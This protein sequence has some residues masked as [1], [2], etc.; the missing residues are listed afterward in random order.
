MQVKLQR[1]IRSCQTAYRKVVKRRVLL[2]LILVP[3]V[4]AT[5][6]VL[7]Q[8]KSAQLSAQRTLL[9]S[10]SS[11]IDGQD[12]S[13]FAG[14][15]QAGGVVSIHSL[16]RA[17]V[18]QDGSPNQGNP[19]VNIRGP[20]LEA[21]GPFQLSWKMDSMSGKDSS[22]QLYSAVPVIYDEWRYEMPHVQFAVV[23]GS[24]TVMVWDGTNDAPVSSK[25]YNVGELTAYSFT[26]D[27][28]G[29]S[30][31]VLVDGQYLAD[32]DLRHD[33]TKG[34]MWF[35]ADAVTDS[36]GW[37]LSNLRAAPLGKSKLYVVKAPVMKVAALDNSLRT[38]AQQTSRHLL[39][40]AAIAENPLLTD[41]H[42]RQIAGG[43]FSMLTPENAM[44][45]QFIHPQRGIYSFEDADSLVEFAQA[46]NMQVHGHAL[47]FGEA[48]PAWM[49]QASLGERQA[50]MTD[51]IKTIV[52]HYKGKV[53]E[54]DVVNE[55]LAD[56]AV[57]DTT[58]S[59][60]RQTIWYQAMGEQ[61]I[62]IA[63]RTARETDP[64]AKLYIN[65][66]GLEADG[67]R[68]DSMLALLG[69][70]KARGVPIDGVG[71]QAHVYEDGDQIDPEVLAR[72]I[73]TLQKMGL[74][75]RI[76]E[77]DVTGDDEQFQANQYAGVLKVCLQEPSCTSF[78]TWGMTDKYGSTTS[79]HTY[80]LDY[81]ND[82]LW[83][84]NF[85][86]KPAYTALQATLEQH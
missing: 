7:K 58:S 35:G 45:A 80:P 84:D 52:S 70:L 50:I 33:Y 28:S 19:P 8:Q 2:V 77:M 69:R 5:L 63:F 6:F 43:Q 42:Y 66:F 57:T 38:L 67:D 56:N 55:P 27:F 41:E 14:A 48:N 1:F 76:S 4:L 23:K 24:V 21:S 22:F 10:E 65:D 12:W 62:D 82:L 11:L 51:H 71:F 26:L 20:H 31:K 64:S 3:L 44:K 54:W 36:N 30:I 74:V 47:V 60:I 81:G 9:S 29:T 32:V 68:W 34:S 59:D 79:L 49:Q 17:I 13:H 75:S 18:N 15:Q 39:I 85:Q 40:G 37:Q 78:T 25:T 46:N 72:H 53:A 83:N 16:G 73:E 86:T 61:Y